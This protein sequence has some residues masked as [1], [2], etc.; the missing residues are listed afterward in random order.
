MSTWPTSGSRSKVTT[1][2]FSGEYLYQVWKQSLQ[3]RE[4]YGMDMISL[5]HIFLQSHEQMT[6]KIWVKVKSRYTYKKRIPPVE[7]NLWSG[8]DFVYRWIDWRTDK[9]KP[10]YLPLNFVGG[11]IIKCVLPTH[12]PGGKQFSIAHVT[13]IKILLYWIWIYLP[14]PAEHLLMNTRTY[15]VHSIVAFLNLSVSFTLPSIQST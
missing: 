3:W 5:S 8:H 7:G 1:P 4:N 6:W 14:I 10:V 12:L 15:H 11:G 9:V 13:N 2:S